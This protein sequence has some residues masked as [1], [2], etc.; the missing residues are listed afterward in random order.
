MGTP[1]P[2]LLRKKREIRQKNQQ[3]GQRGYCP[4]L[5]GIACLIRALVLHWMYEMGRFLKNWEQGIKRKYLNTCR[6]QVFHYISNHFNRVVFANSKGICWLCTPTG[7]GRRGQRPTRA[8][9]NTQRGT[10]EEHSLLHEPTL[11]QR[12]KQAVF[13]RGLFYFSLCWDQT[14]MCLYP[15]APWLAQRWSYKGELS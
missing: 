4:Y 11:P 9:R 8:P 10:K 2:A 14:V 6:L 3:T 12:R 5:R 13:W 1:R 7:K 15:L